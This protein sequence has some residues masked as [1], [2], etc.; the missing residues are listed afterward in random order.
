MHTPGLCVSLKK[1]ITQSKSCS[2]ETEQER[3]KALRGKQPVFS[4]FLLARVNPTNAYLKKHQRAEEMAH[5]IM[6]LLCKYEDPSLDPQLPW[7]MRQYVIAL[8]LVG[9]RGQIDRSQGFAVK[10]V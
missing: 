4:S 9:R 6:G 1:V 7:K 5:G 8:I 10:S 2:Q 3:T